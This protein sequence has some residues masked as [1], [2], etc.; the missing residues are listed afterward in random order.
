MW[1]IF[2]YPLH[3]FVF[4]KYCTMIC[5]FLYP[6]Q[7]TIKRDILPKVYNLYLHRIVKFYVLFCMITWYKPPD[8]MDSLACF[9]KNMVHSYLLPCRCVLIIHCH[10]QPELPGTVHLVG[11][12]RQTQ[13]RAD[14][15]CVCPHLLPCDFSGQYC[16][17][18]GFL[19]GPLPPHTHVLLPH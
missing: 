4:S 11:F 3:M 19:P 6:K 12:L 9:I 5:N 7:K 14:P 2:S 17:Y 13:A 16:H 8:S 18:L 10:D 15:L 1:V